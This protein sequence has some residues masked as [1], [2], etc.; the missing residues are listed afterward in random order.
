[1]AN[2][3]NKQMKPYGISR[4]GANDKLRD[5]L[6]M[7]KQ[8]CTTS[9]PVSDEGIAWKHDRALVA[10]Q[11]FGA[12][13]PPVY[14]AGGGPDVLELIGQHAD[15]WFT[16]I[17]GA[18]DDSPE[19]FAHDVATIRRH[20][21]QAGRDPASIRIS[22]TMIGLVDDDEEHLA[23][24]REHPFVLWNTMLATP[25]SAT[26]ARWGLEHPYGDDFM[27]SRDCIP[28]WVSREEALDVCAR[29]PREAIDKVHFYG[30]PE[31]VLARLEPYLA[32]DVIDELSIVS[33]AELCGLKY[34]ATAGPAVARLLRGL[35]G[36]DA[37]GTGAISTLVGR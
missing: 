29:T 21:E 11:P 23:E 28:P 14:V 8:F 17:P 20:A 30:T 3:E 12:A 2:G 31:T 19:Q 24:L 25:T 36:A 34:M 33:Y 26:F 6:R 32:L 27:F 1:M 15:G 13:P 37:P 18:S 9:E 4:K 5:S 16:Y 22:A 35:K 10:L 7:V